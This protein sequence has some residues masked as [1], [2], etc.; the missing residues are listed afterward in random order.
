LGTVAAFHDV[1]ELRRVDQVRR[2][3]IANASH[4][5]RTP[6]TSILGFARTLAGS[7]VSA[8][9][10]SQYLKVIVRNAQR[11]SSLIDDLLTLSRIESGAATL[12]RTALDEKRVVET[13]SADFGPR[14]E[15]VSIRVELHAGT[16]PMA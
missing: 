10:R 5:L 2:D 11:M 8:E 9:E 16:V 1:P 3:F 13:V 15:E 4:E 7:E 6:L 14:F 12:E